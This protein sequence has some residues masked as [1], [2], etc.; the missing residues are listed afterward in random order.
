A[1]R[2]RP[3]CAWRRPAGSR[4]QEVLEVVLAADAAAEAEDLARHGV[5]IDLDV[6]AL[7]APQEARAGDELVGLEGTVALDAQLLQG[8]MDPAALHVVRVDVDH[9]Q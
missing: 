9:R 4:S 1:G 8:Q 7:S 6:V 2:A 5:R 3:S